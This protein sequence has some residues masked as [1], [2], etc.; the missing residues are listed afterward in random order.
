MKKEEG[1]RLLRFGTC[2]SRDIVV[3]KLCLGLGGCQRLVLVDLVMMMRKGRQFVVLPITANAFPKSFTRL[4]LS[5][6]QC[7]RIVQTIIIRFIR[8]SNTFGSILQYLINSSFQ[9][10]L[11][12]LLIKSLSCHPSW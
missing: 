1:R 4:H 12:V 2:Y 3:T 8:S 11:L 10:R 6:W 5:G 7:R 9:G